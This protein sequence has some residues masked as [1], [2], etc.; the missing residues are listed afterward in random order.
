[1]KQIHILAWVTVAL[2]C[3]CST[4]TENIQPDIENRP[5]VIAKSNEIEVNIDDYIFCMNHQKLGMTPKKLTPRIMANERFQRDTANLCLQKKFLRQYAKENNIIPTEEEYRQLYKK[6]EVP[7]EIELAEQLEI[8]TKQAILLANDIIYPE[9]IQKHLILNI[10]QESLFKKYISD[11]T[12]YTLQVVIVDNTHSDEKILKQTQLNREKLEEYLQPRIKE[13]ESPPNV[14]FINAKCT[15]FNLLRCK[16]PSQTTTLDYYSFPDAFRNPV[17]TIYLQTNP[18]N[19]PEINLKLVTKLIPNKPPKMTEEFT[20]KLA[21]DFLKETRLSTE[22]LT[23]MKNCLNNETPEDLNDC[24]Q[25]S[26][27]IKSPQILSL[28]QISFTNLINDTRINNYKKTLQ[29]IQNTRAEEY[30]LYANPTI[31]NRKIITFKVIKTDIPDKQNFIKNKH[32]YTKNL[33]NNPFRPQ[34]QSLIND[35]T[36]KYTTLNLNPI[37]KIYGTLGFD[38]TIKK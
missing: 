33:I 27:D 12:L 17:N 21:A 26:P 31:E 25:N 35:N 1:M 28:E 3:A 13:Y 34:L 20:K 16:F 22:T 6:L 30:N 10:D 11:E 14:E 8:S 7:T 32:E 23:A 15:S 36:S 2:M 4:N 19:K 37:K 5:V 29:N 9:R 24:L 18:D 38:G